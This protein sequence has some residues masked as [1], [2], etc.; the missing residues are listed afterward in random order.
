VS[1][2]VSAVV[3]QFSEIFLPRAVNFSQL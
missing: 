3:I 1:A 2:V